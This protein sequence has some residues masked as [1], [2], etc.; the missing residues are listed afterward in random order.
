MA[1]RTGDIFARH[2][3]AREMRAFRK[4][5]FMFSYVLRRLAAA[6]PSSPSPNNATAVGSGTEVAVQ[7]PMQPGNS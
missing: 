4:T 7:S 5:G 1:G 2:K 6:K 3:K